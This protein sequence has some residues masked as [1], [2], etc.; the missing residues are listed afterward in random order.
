MRIR[1]WDSSS[2][3]NNSGSDGNDADEKGAMGDDT[4]GIRAAAIVETEVIAAV[5]IH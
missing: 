5:K 2:S 4:R 1:K 3:S